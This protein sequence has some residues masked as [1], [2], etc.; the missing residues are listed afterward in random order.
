MRLNFFLKHALYVN[1][2]IQTSPITKK[3]KELPSFFLTVN[4]VAG[5]Y[6]KCWLYALH[7]KHICSFV[8]VHTQQLIIKI[9]SCCVYTTCTHAC[10]VS[11]SLPN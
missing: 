9:M 1:M 4:S 7:A 5:N 8:P 11:V 2:E 10:K 6:H 3:Y